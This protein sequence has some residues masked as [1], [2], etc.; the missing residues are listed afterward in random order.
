MIELNMTMDT[1]K[2]PLLVKNTDRLGK[3]GLQEVT[4][5]TQHRLGT[6]THAKALLTLICLHLLCSG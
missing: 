6:T 5:Q 4:A 3:R 2:S 1:K